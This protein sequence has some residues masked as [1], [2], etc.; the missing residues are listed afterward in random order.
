MKGED[1]KKMNAKYKI[2]KMFKCPIFNN[3]TTIL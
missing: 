2:P 3:Y 1:D